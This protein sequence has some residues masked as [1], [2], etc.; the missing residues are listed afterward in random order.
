MVF[1]PRQEILLQQID[2]FDENWSEYILECLQ[3]LPAT[4]L[5]SVFNDV[6]QVF[7]KSVV[8]NVSKKRTTNYLNLLCDLGVANFVSSTNPGRS[9][10]V[11]MGSSK[12]EFVGEATSAYMGTSTWLM[13]FYATLIC[14][15]IDSTRILCDVPEEVFLRADFK[16]DEFDLAMVRVSK[17]LFDASV[18]IGQL[19]IEA[20]DMSEE[21]NIAPD[22]LEFSWMILL[23]TLLL[24][25]FAIEGDPDK[26]YD[27]RFE[28]ALKQHTSFWQSEE[29]EVD[30]RGW[31]SLP[32]TAVAS[33]VYDNRGVEF[34]NNNSLVPRWLVEE[35]R[36]QRSER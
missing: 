29:W 11:P 19:L 21:E 15:K 32:L 26:V 3:K 8:A 10:Y 1:K 25:R 4:N 22:R 27:D 34:S 16:A 17:G 33:I 35:F 24:Y 7:C 36:P 14:G 18:D 5:G 28:Y 2:T 30:S 23:P 31:V 20:I 9:I 6:F 12:I 13:A